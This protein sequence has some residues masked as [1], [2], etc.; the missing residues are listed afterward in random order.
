MPDATPH[1][2]STTPSGPEDRRSITTRLRGRE[3]TAHTAGGVFSGD[4]LDLGT[5]VLLRE[6]PAPPSA[7]VFLDLGCGWG[8]ITLA[9]AHEAP[10]AQVWAVDV[11]PRARELT[12]ENARTQGAGGVTVAAPDEVPADLRF[13]LIWSNP[14]IR[15]GKAELHALLSRWLVRLAPGG[16]AWLVVQRNLGG[17]SLHAWLSAELPKLMNP[18]VRVT[19]AG[20]A[21][22]FRVLRIEAPSATSAPGPV[23][24]DAP[25]PLQA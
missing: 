1:Y 14:P 9:L 17:D 7:G 8:P 24:G 5:S 13:D 12:A 20:S 6:V 19:R 21:K 10:Q 18:E 15:I 4:R 11:N 2:F 23:D 16:V 3:V 22:G 25:E